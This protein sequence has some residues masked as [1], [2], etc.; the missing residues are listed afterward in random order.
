MAADCLFCKIAAGAIPSAQLYDDA[1]AFAF[2]DITPLAPGHALVIPKK[3]AVTFEDLSSGDA[4]A[5]FAAVHRVG[6]ALAAATGT[7][8]S[9]IAINNGKEAGQE[10]PHVHVHVVPRQ[11]GDG[12]G[13]IHGLFGG[14]KPA[15]KAALQ[16][17]A[18][19]VRKSL[20]AKARA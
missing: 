8:G 20:T 6:A 15:D 14:G 4:A 9:T 19:K 17:L 5:L 3:H 12:H 11:A 10:V 13:P 18:E 2:L 1:S 16:A 7:K